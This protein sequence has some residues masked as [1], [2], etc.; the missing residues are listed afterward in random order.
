LGT[1]LGFATILVAVTTLMGF[2]NSRYGN[3]GAGIAAAI[4]GVFDVH[5]SA[6]STLSLAANG[7]LKPSELL[8]PILIAFSTNTA[9]KLVAAFAS[10]GPCY[11]IPVALGLLT[12]ASAAWV[13]SFWLG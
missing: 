4:T 1:A 2:I 9:S 11:G 8:L 7:A 3:V 6:A 13:P 5:A 12:I 10:G